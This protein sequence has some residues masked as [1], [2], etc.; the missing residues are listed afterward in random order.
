M[1][2]TWPS[3][4]FLVLFFGGGGSGSKQN[5]VDIA[6]GRYEASTLKCHETDITRC[7]KS[8]LLFSTMLHRPSC[9]TCC[10]SHGTTIK[11][12]S[13]KSIVLWREKPFKHILFHSLS[14][15]SNKLCGYYIY[16]L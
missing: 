8:T 9:E 13:S 4:F 14:P 7:G 6:I 5:P 11:I 12:H 15:L 3:H 16:F 1:R 2:R 10:P